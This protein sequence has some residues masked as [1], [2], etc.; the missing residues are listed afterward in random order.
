MLPYAQL[1]NF[2]KYSVR[3][4]LRRK[5]PFPFCFLSVS[6]ISRSK[7]HIMIGVNV[8]YFWCATNPF[9]DRPFLNTLPFYIR[10]ASP[11]VPKSVPRSLEVKRKKKYAESWLIRKKFVQPKDRKTQ[12][13]K[14]NGFLQMVKMKNWR[15]G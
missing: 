10:S 9:T 11:P 13:R 5:S 14:C 7:F 6:H 15:G 3:P 1:K 8:Q 2:K 12:R 4:R